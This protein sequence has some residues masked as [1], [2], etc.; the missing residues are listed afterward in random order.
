MHSESECVQLHIENNEAYHQHMKGK[1]GLKNL[2]NSPQ[3]FSSYE[4]VEREG[5]T[6]FLDSASS[7]SLFEKSQKFTDSK[8]T[9]IPLFLDNRSNV[10]AKGIGTAA[11]ISES[12]KPLNAKNSLI[13]TSRSSPLITL[14]PFLRKNF[15]LVGKGDGE[16][17]WT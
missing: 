1:E 16:E 14:V 4:K 7:F 11:I 2:R 10:N 9:V 8:E 17:L 6:S 5:I 13:L 15:F 3:E 12:E